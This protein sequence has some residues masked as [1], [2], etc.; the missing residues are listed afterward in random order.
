MQLYLDTFLTSQGVLGCC[1]Y[2]CKLIGRAAGW[3]FHHLSENN[4]IPISLS[5]YLSLL[6]LSNISKSAMILTKENIV[7]AKHR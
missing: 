1:G 2:C 6:L 3:D 5:C 4:D 7:P